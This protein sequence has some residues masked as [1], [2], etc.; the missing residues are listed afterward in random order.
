MGRGAQLAT[1]SRALEAARSATGA[2]MLVSGEAGIGK[3]RLVAELRVHA[4]Q[5]SC[6]ILQGTCFESDR[7]LPYA[8]LV[9]VLRTLIAQ[10]PA[11][12]VDAWLRPFAPQ[13]VRAVPELVDWLAGVTP[14]PALEPEA[15][16][17]RILHSFGRLF[18]RIASD[19]ALVIVLEDLQWSDAASAGPS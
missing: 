14:A 2:T 7:A 10:Q 3:S 8:P 15:E 11:E 5:L 6:L 18:A 13:L 16:K 9:D 19:R 12:T 1:L 17:R 4:K